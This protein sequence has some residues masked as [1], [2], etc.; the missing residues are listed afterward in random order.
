MMQPLK[1]NSKF[2]LPQFFWA[3]L[4]LFPSVLV[5]EYFFRLWRIDSY[6]FFPVLLLSVGVMFFMN[7]DGLLR[8]PD[9]RLA[10]VL[11]VVGLVIAVVGTMLG[12]PWLGCLSSIVMLSAFFSS[13]S[14]RGK[15]ECGML[16]LLPP[17]LL[18]LR[19]PLGLDQVLTGS[20]QTITSIV[21][22][23]LLEL[24]GI[25]HRLTGNVFFLADG[26][27]F[28]EEACSGIQSLFSLLFVALLMVA[29]LRRSNFLIPFYLAFAA[30]WSLAMNILRVTAIAVAQDWFSID[31]AHGWQH[32]VLGYTC[33]L[34]AI[35]L[36]WSTD[37]LFLVCFFPIPSNE[38]AN[39]NVNPIS[40]FWNRHVAMFDA[41]MNSEKET[42]EQSAT[43]CRVGRI[44]RFASWAIATIAMVGV[45][46]ANVSAFQSL[47]RVQ[48]RSEVDAWRPN[49]DLL[50]SAS[51][52]LQVLSK[53]E[54]VRSDEPA[55][56]K[57]S[58]LWDCLIDGMP[59]RIAVSQHDEYHDLCKC[60]SANGWRMSAHEILQSTSGSNEWSFVSAR[61]TNAELANGYLV[62][63]S[64]TH[65]GLPIQA[66]RQGLAASIV[67]RFGDRQN[68]SLSSYDANTM[69]IQ[70]WII[71]DRTLPP[72]KIEKIVAVHEEVRTLIQV[73]V[74]DKFANHTSGN[75]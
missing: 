33:L 26:A 37:R 66:R 50:K 61:F 56:G 72:E 47:S 52:Y 29:W 22:S 12:S 57:F 14:E 35:L 24:L 34:L 69:N 55:L 7:W 23:F 28:V 1:M 63:S 25:V 44:H 48:V 71:S 27:L 46:P 5:V 45:I 32:E 40:A 17:C 10:L 68:Q 49:D 2:G 8:L 43:V 54:S 15:K 70:F 3:A 41:G 11:V 4:F 51:P 74:S 38:T 39:R 58:I 65:S 59:M 60:Y 30:L 13:Q 62:F 20:L 16:F 73:S 67:Q 19:L 21:S 42:R 6:Q 18:L 64:L 31:L 75:R 36:L 9:S 53:T